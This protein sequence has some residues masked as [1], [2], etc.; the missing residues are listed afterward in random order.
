MREVSCGSSSVGSWD[1][2]LAGSILRGLQAAMEEE[3]LEVV[4]VVVVVVVG[5]VS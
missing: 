1:N 2:S 4:V 5:V 3:E